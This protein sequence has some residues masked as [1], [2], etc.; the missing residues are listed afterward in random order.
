MGN[1]TTK[2]MGK[3]FKKANNSSSL[4]GEELPTVFKSP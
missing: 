1:V 4:I 2:D 3:S